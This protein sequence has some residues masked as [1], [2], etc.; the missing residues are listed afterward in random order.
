MLIY[1]Y[2][3]ESRFCYTL[4]YFL[5]KINAQILCKTV[6]LLKLLVSA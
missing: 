5:Y 6:A 4:V 3:V 2:I 1:I